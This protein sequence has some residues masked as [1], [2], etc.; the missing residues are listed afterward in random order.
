MLAANAT[1]EIIMASGI[2]SNMVMSG[3]PG[4]GK[5]IRKIENY[6]I[7]KNAKLKNIITRLESFRL[8]RDHISH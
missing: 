4:V 2:T 1:I 6:Q 3:K 7:H 8:Y 5:L